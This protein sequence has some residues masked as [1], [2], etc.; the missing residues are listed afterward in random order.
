MP[1]AQLEAP[2]QSAVFA[3]ACFG[4]SCGGTRTVYA[5]A[6]AA[7]CTTNLRTKPDTR[8]VGGG[9]LVFADGHA[10]RMN[11]RNVAA[12]C[13]LLFRPYRADWGTTYWSDWCG[14][15]AD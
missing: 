9:N 10:K 14:G 7:A 12:Q 3:D 15:P 1:L 6:C 5:N 13:G 2:A 4:L 11:H 8:H